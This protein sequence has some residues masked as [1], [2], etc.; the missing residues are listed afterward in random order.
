M[1]RLSNGQKFVMPSLALTAIGVDDKTILADSILDELLNLLL[2]LLLGRNTRRVDIPCSR[3]N[4]VLVAIVL[5]DGD[6]FE[7]ALGS[8]DGDD[9]GIESSNVLKNVIEV[10][11]E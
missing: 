9:V 7:V 3:T 10:T 11:C 4:I 2:E 6:E 5:E 8:L 1:S